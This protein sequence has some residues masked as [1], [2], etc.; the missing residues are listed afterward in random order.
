[1]NATATTGRRRIVRS[2]VMATALL[3]PAAASGPAWADN[4]TAAFSA[5]FA[6]INTAATAFV[7]AA[8]MVDVAAIAPA[9]DIDGA[10]AGTDRD[11]IH[12]IGGG[13]ASY[14]ADKFNG[15]RTASGES[16]SN[17]ALTAAH[18]SLPFGTRLQ[19]T[20]PA[21]GHSVIVRVNDR[22]PFHAGRLID[23]S[24]AAASRLGIVA[25]GSG[26]VEL[27]RLD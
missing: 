4:G 15:H 11:D 21:N 9:S 16:F 10:D 17:S 12:T 22:G 20:N 7:P 14:Y 18:R 3:L 23:L 1:M 8:G 2:A 13:V 5:A 19:V 6:P 26:R 24:K 27:A 25:R